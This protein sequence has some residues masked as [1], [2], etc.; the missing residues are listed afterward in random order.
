MK[1][2]VNS[3][4]LA[5]AVNKV[6]K[7]C[8][9]KFE[10]KILE[11]IKLSAKNDT[12]I[13]TAFDSEMSIETKIKCETIVDGETVINGK[14]LSEYANKLEGNE[15]VEIAIQPN[16]Q[17]L[18]KCGKLKFTLSTMGASEFPLIAID[19]V[20]NGFKIDVADLK[21]L[22][23]R[24][25]FCAA[26]D[27]ARPILKGVALEARGGGELVACALDGFR[28]A[29]ATTIVKGASQGLK[30]IVP[31]R[32]LVELIKSIEKDVE[33]ILVNITKNHLSVTTA[34]TR[35]TTRLFAGQFV[36]FDSL[37]ESPYET[38]ALVNREE[39]ISVLDR[40]S[41]LAK[42]SS[43]I[44][45][46]GFYDGELSILANADI[47]EM[48]EE[49]TVNQVGKNKVIHLNYKYLL[50]CLKAVDYEQV[51]LQVRD[52]QAP[53]FV[54]SGSELDNAWEYLILPIRVNI[55]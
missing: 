33:S 49:M 31:A 9:D 25:V 29:K 50:D 23:N 37:L 2:V 26:T 55:G 32:C 13:L 20:E 18:I 43:N 51:E 48:H 42:S 27:D 12:L 14:L 15:E 4:D 52:S 35:F 6:A 24:V 44:V 40:A 39:L 53:M 54:R 30:C 17:A 19:E 45:K 21:T 8:T 34:K 11:G 28:L 36:N 1:V 47:G 5:E 41:I 7:A 3:Y 38:T 16:T 46:L 22:V 10:P